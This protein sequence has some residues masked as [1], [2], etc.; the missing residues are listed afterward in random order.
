MSDFFVADLHFGHANVIRYSERPYATIE[1]MDEALVRLWNSVVGKDD[2]VFMLGD[3]ALA[4]RTYIREVVPKL[5][6]KKILVRGNHDSYNSPFYVEA[7]FNAVSPLPLLYD[8]KAHGVEGQFLLSHQPVVSLPEGLINI[9]GHIHN[10]ENP[11]YYA[12]NH[13]CVSVEMTNYRPVSL[14]QVLTMLAQKRADYRARD[15]CG[16]T[17]VVFDTRDERLN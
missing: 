16:P 12:P 11:N 8:Q 13:I 4:N 1:K 9:H 6:G 10:N 15:I 17:S 14:R 3:F 7:G 2:R 5:H